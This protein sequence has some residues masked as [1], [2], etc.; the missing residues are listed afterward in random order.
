[1][2]FSQLLIGAKNNM[3]LQHP[4]PQSF[5]YPVIALSTHSSSSRSSHSSCCLLQVTKEFVE[6]WAGTLGM[7]QSKLHA[8]IAPSGTAMKRTGSHTRKKS[9]LNGSPSAVCC[10]LK[11]GG[12]SALLCTSLQRNGLSIHCAQRGCWPLSTVKLPIKWI[13]C[14]YELSSECSK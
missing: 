2:L 3:Q 13:E 11:H 12:R 9:W 4:F 6:G 7:I 1:M 5:M 10:F 8:K 14:K